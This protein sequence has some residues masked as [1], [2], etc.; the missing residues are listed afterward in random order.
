MPGCVW[1]ENEEGNDGHLS[2]RSG[3]SLRVKQCGSFNPDS[4]LA[5]HVKAGWKKTNK[6]I[7]LAPVPA[8]SHFS[9]LKYRV[10][11]SPFSYNGWSLLR[12][13][14]TNLGT[15]CVPHSQGHSG[16]FPLPSKLSPALPNHLSSVYTHS[17]P[18]HSHLSLPQVFELVFSASLPPRAHQCLFLGFLWANIKHPIINIWHLCSLIKSDRETKE[19]FLQSK[20]QQIRSPTQFTHARLF[21]LIS[22]TYCSHTELSILQRGQAH[23]LLRTFALAVLSVENILFLDPFVAPFI[24]KVSAQMLPPQRGLPWPPI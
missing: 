22:Y 13:G 2:S 4:R 11:T 10:E 9:N 12:V 17:Q 24:I 7:F 3:E 16:S 6:Q 5:F 18:S 1:E 15:E 23:P 21:G 8:H 20:Q 19:W 14:S